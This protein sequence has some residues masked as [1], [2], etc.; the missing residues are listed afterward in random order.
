MPTV[1]RIGPY[2]FVYFSSDHPEP[3]HIHVKRDRCIAK[4]WL[5]A[6]SLDKSKGFAEHE[7]NDIEKLVRDNRDHLL[8]AWHEHFGA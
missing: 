6:V 4:F 3:P 7:L 5:E 8:E 1:L 2:S